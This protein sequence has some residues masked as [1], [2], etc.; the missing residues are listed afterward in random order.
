MPQFTL[1]GADKLVILALL[2]A[3]VRLPL[4]SFGEGR[5]VRT[6]P[7]NRKVANG[8]PSMYFGEGK[9]HRDNTKLS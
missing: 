9:C 7:W 4:P 5:K 6:P 8:D 1:T 2:F 3:S